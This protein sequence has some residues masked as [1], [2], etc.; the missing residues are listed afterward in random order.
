MCQRAAWAALA[1]RF[2][3]TCRMRSGSHRH[4]A[5]AS[6]CSSRMDA[7]AGSLAKTS[8]VS[9]AT[10]ARSAWARRGTAGRAY[11]RKRVTSSFSRD[12][13]RVT[14]SMSRASSGAS[15]SP[16]RRSSIDPDMAAT[17]LRS[18]WARPAATRPMSASRSLRC[19][20]SSM[21]R[22]PERSW[23]M[24]ARPMGLPS[25]PR[26]AKWVYPRRS[27]SPRTFSKS[28]SSRPV[29]SCMP[30]EPARGGLAAHLL[31]PEAGDLLAG[32]VQ[33]GDAVLRVEGDEPRRHRLDDG[34]L[35]GRDRLQ[36][37]LAGLELLAGAPEL[38]G[39]V[40]GER[41]RGHEGAGVGEERQ[42]GGPPRR[43][44]EHQ[45]TRRRRARARARRPCRRGRAGSPP[46]RWRAST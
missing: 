8:R 44:Q 17:G 36:V 33:E 12:A 15:A 30:G 26:S 27:R 45:R 9:E 28:V 10:R 46:P 42:D 37:G 6:S 1:S 14:M 11:S 41:R 35:Q 16:V 4:A 21:A 34:L 29:C 25:R 5:G 38:L 19:T 20:R 31:G 43:Q 18:S 39:E 40:G 24:T 32:P 7:A 3:S 2:Q 13:S 23:K 22:S